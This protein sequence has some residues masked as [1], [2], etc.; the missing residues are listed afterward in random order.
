MMSIHL[1]SIPP[2]AAKP[3]TNWYV[4]F[5][6]THAAGTA[7]GE[8][9][10]WSVIPGGTGIEDPH[11]NGEMSFSGDG[12]SAGTAKNPAEKW[13]AEYNAK[14]REVPPEWKK[15]PDQLPP[16]GPWLFRADPVEQGVKDNWCA[17]DATT[18]DWVPVKVPA[19]WNETEAVGNYQGF[20]WYR[21]RFTL[22]EAWRGKSLRLMFGSVDEQAWIYVNGKLVREHSEKSEGKTYGVLWEESFTADVPSGS[23]NFGKDKPNILAVRVN[24]STANGGIWRPVM[25]CAVDKE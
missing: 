22:P 9:Y 1:K 14:T 10:V 4:N 7:Q 8:P 21:T 12:S 23:L 16:L 3:D 24:N 6:R 2:A 11:G 20:G 15:L 25:G 13:R 5:Q 18:D 19:F 17:A